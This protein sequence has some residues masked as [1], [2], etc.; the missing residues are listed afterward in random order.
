MLAS[1]TFASTSAPVT[2]ASGRSS[3]T[4][5]S[6]RGFQFVSEALRRVG[7][8]ADLTVVGDEGRVHHVV[9]VED[10]VQGGAGEVPAGIILLLV[11]RPRTATLFQVVHVLPH[12]PRWRL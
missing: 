8:L 11:G 10:C 6:A 3:A 1:A 5:E 9:S 12:S 4:S 7:Y 2:S